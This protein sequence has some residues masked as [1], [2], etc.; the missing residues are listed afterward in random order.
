MGE[1]ATGSMLDRLAEFWMRL[2]RRGLSRFESGAVA[3]GVAGLM[4]GVLIGVTLPAAEPE[5]DQLV[6]LDIPLDIYDAARLQA[7][8]AEPKSRPKIQLASNRRGGREVA[9]APFLQETGSALDDAKALYCMT[10]AV[11][12]E[13]GSESLD[14]KRAVAQV[15]L[16]RV[17]DPNYP[18]SVC[19]VVFQRGYKNKGC[20]FSFT[21]NGDM[22]RR[23]YP[24]SWAASRDVAEAA[25]AGYVMPTVG[26]ATHYHADYVSPD[27]GR[28]LA[29]VTTIGAHI[30]YRNHRQ[31]S[32]SASAPSFGEDAS[33]SATVERLNAHNPPVIATTETTPP[34]TL[35]S[36]E[37]PAPH[38][39]T[40]LTSMPKPTP[41]PA[42]GHPG[43]P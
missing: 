15:V 36:K 35:A 10:A 41:R 17:R 40:V 42:L 43:A 26:R 21:C 5:P 29:R 31:P 1:G 2:R 32:A 24:P 12:Y 34:V 20:Q 33:V 39:L 4:F 30:F 37:E 7:Q 25:L 6:T 16:N 19:G 3:G 38:P 23:P 28:T 22:R 9:A 18:K 13:A 8:A 11:Y 27:W 14:G